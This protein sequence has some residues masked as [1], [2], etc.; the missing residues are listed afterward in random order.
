MSE[1]SGCFRNR[2]LTVALPQGWGC[3]FGGLARHGFDSLRTAGATL[4]QSREAR[5]ARSVCVCT[6]V[7]SSAL[8][9]SSMR[10]CKESNGTLMK[11]LVQYA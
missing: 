8:L 10:C 2:K 3:S 9:C 11:K 5:K 7:I 6:T 4:R 1:S